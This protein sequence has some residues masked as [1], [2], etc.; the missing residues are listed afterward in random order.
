MTD[1]QLAACRANAQLSTGPRTAEGKR[2]SCLNAFRHGLTG[3]ILIHT[4]ED[5]QA[6]QKHCDAI[7]QALAPVGPLELDLAQ[8]IAEDKWRLHRARALE[9]SVFAL[10]HRERFQRTAPGT[11]TERSFDPNNPAAPGCVVRWVPG[12]PNAALPEVDAALAQGQT[13]I[14]QAKNLQLLTL[15]EQRIRR[16]VEKNTAELK[17]L[18]AERKAAFAKAEEEA[19]LLVKL[20]QSEGD[21]HDPSIDFPPESQPLGFVFS[22]ASIE[23][24]LERENRLHR[25]LQLEKTSRSPQPQPLRAAGIAA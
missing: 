9:N 12:D 22:R 20:A 5:Q 4:S 13:W 14:A 21:N 23:R 19:R 2:R 3:Q 11:G 7:V 6:L 1:A 24:Q 10:G 17:A 25:A 16:S 15:Y 8:A 18:Q